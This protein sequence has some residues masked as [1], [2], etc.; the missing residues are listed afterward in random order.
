MSKTIIITPDGTI[1]NLE[2]STSSNKDLLNLYIESEEELQFRGYERL[3]AD[4]LSLYLA[5]INYIVIHDEDTSEQIY[6]GKK[7]TEKQKD[8]Y[9]YNKKMFNG[10]YLD[11]K[12]INE[13]DCVEFYSITINS[14]NNLDKIITNKCIERGNEDVQRIR[15]KRRNS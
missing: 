13:D 8:T 11:V 15:N 4:Y 6:I 5:G 1:N 12:A 10:K 14:K 2:S 3:N 7:I 9:F